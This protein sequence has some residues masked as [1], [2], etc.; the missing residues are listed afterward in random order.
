MKRIKPKL[1]IYQK[2]E[3]GYFL[4]SIFHELFSI[5]DIPHY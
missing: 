5:Y 2:K 3:K 1:K 4:F